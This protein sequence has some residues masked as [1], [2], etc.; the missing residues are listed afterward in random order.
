MSRLRA[1]S[2]RMISVRGVKGNRFVGRHAA[3]LG[4]RQRRCYTQVTWLAPFSPGG[5]FWK[6]AGGGASHRAR[7]T[8]SV[9]HHTPSSRAHPGGMPESSATMGVPHAFFASLRDASFIPGR[10]GSLS[11]GSRSQSLASPPATFQRPSGT[12][13]L[14]LSVGMCNNE[15]FNPRRSDDPR[16]RQALKAR[17]MGIGGSVDVTNATPA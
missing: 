12:T 4:P 17:F 3:S 8:G 5:T 1:T 10:C 11:G 16:S 14:L 6:L 7:T 13:A 9:N 2:L 15:G